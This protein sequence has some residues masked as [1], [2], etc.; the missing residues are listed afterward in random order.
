MIKEI[1]EMMVE[2]NNWMQQQRLKRKTTNI[3]MKQVRQTQNDA[4]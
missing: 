2:I 1:P 4:N 3:I